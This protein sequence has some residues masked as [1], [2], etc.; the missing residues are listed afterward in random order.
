MSEIHVSVSD[1]RMKVVTAPTLASG[2]INEVKVVFNFCGKWDGF[3]KT[4]IFYRDIDKIYYAVLDENDICI[5]P[6]EVYAEDGT[7]YASVFGEKDDTRRTSTIVRYKVGKGIVAEELLPSEPSPEVYDQIIELYQD[8]KT[9][10]QEAQLSAKRT[11]E[12]ADKIGNLSETAFQEL[13]QDVRDLAQ[14]V[15]V[16][17]KTVPQNL[18]DASK[19]Q[20]RKNIDAAHIDDSKVA[21]DETWS[22]QKISDTINGKTLLVTYDEQGDR[23]SHSAAGIYNH[24]INGGIVY[25]HHNFDYIPLSHAFEEYADF[26]L[27]APTTKTKTVYRIDNACTVSVYEQ[28]IGEGGS[29]STDGA[30]LYTSQNL[31][32]EQKAQARTNIG[33][34]GEAD[35]QQFYRDTIEELDV[36]VKTVKQTFGDTS[37]AQARENIGAACV[38][39]SKIGTDTWSS[40]K[41][42]AYIDET[43]LGGA[44]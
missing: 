19:K 43:I 23:T 4:A 38:D 10:A 5:L 6:W 21:E 1:Q 39:D 41:I 27:Y 24:V 40:K 12:A 32:P 13:D 35:Y 37:K 42:I 9:L 15:S 34:V 14:D 28:T 33:A 29:G 7:F 17:V 11:E 30:V 44:W 8:T 36:T 20:A 2:G 16:T 3:V 25:L 22:S 18:G 31:T 26:A